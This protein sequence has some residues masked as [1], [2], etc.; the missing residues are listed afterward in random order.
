MLQPL[1]SSHCQLITPQNDRTATLR[2]V[3]PLPTTADPRIN[4]HSHFDPPPATATHRF[5][6]VLVDVPRPVA[7]VGK[8]GLVGHVVHEQDAHGAAGWQWQWVAVA[9]AVVRQ[10]Q[11]LGSGSGSGWQWQW[12]W[13]G[14][15][16]GWRL[17]SGWQLGSGWVAVVGSWAV[18]GSGRWQWQMVVDGSGWQWLVRQWQVATPVAVVRQWMA[19]AV[20]RQWM[21]VISDGHGHRWMGASGRQWQVAV[22]GGSGSGSGWQVAVVRQ[23][24]GVA[25][26]RWQWQWMAVDEWQ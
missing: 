5:R 13:L 17:G 22:A 21:A 24:T 20:V 19:V 1:P 11:W 14:S 16:S 4:S 10:W 2:R 8:G 23:W 25:V 3:M 6:G 9:V 15:G 26:D 12:Q 7:D 18:D